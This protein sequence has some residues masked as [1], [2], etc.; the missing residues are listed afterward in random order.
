MP[1]C[2]ECGFESSRLQWTHFKYNCTGRFKNGKEYMN[3]YPFAKVVDDELAKRTAVTLVTLINKYGEKD[4]RIKWEAYRQKQAK[5]NTFEYKQE[6]YGWTAD[7]FDQY[8]VSR[9]ITVENMVKKHGVE[10]GL[11]KWEEYCDRQKFTK[12]KEYIVNTYGLQYWNDL[13]QKK[14]APHKAELVAIKYDITI[15]EAVAK[16]AARYRSSY[17]STLE[18]EFVK[19]LE[20]TL[21]KLDNTNLTSPFGKWNHIKN[22]YVVYDIKH[23]DCIIEFNGD[24]WHANPKIYSATDQIRGTV[25]S[26]IWEKD[27]IKLDIAHAA[28]FRTFVVWESDYLTNKE[29]IIKEIVE[30]MQTTPK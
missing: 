18:L 9:A 20:K 16:I 28:G 26:D 27:R 22:S 5:S 30:W 15:D 2:L 25:A 4:G 29:M 17:S 24:Y 8:N 13:C 6:K 10:D 7:E 1:K 3:A 14:S 23:N 12:S 19:E 11:C 21:G